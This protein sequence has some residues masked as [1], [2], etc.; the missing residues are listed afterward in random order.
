MQSKIEYKPHPYQE[1][2]TQFI[3][4]HK[5][6]GLLLDMGLGK[7]IITLS[8]IWDLCLDSFEV[9]RVLVVA[10][11]RVCKA[12]WP[13]EI[14]KFS[15]LEGLS[16]SVVV[17]S[18][19]ERRAALAKKAFVYIINRENLV[20]LIEEG[21]FN[22][23]LLVL[24]EL[25]SFKSYNTKRFRAL[26]KVRSS[27]KRVIGL[28]GTPGDLMS[29]WPQIYLLDGGERL[30]HFITA[31][32]NKYFLPDKR[33][34]TTIFS[35]KPKEGAEDII[36]EKISDI[37]ISMKSADYLDMPK[38][39]KNNVEV[40]MDEKE[41]ALYEQLKRDL[42]VPMVDGDIDAQSAVGLS[43]KLMQM[44]SGM[45]YD[46]NGVAK[47]IHD[48][49]LDVVEDLIESAAGRPI[50]IAY[51]FKFDKE[52]LIERFGAVPIESSED[53]DSWNRDEIPVGIIHPASASMGI[54]LQLG[55]CRSLVYL[56]TPW[57]LELKAQCDARLYRQGQKNTITIYHLVSKNT[58][59]ED[60]LAALDRKD[61]TQEAILAAVKAR[62]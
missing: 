36:Y 8:A 7:T 39:V 53:I 58:I 11:L 60:I 48:R 45:V 32:R 47:K 33:N 43:L 54:N 51:W 28:T 3:L 34:Q 10:P 15:N 13:T 9:S 59:D 52:R 41:T 18:A 2:C 16:Y 21:Y 19:K 57:S 55:S 27:V 12:T 50:L 24:D 49:K 25:S 20:W 4:N 35:W 5:S 62:I 26:K 56:T 22:F 17:G 6:C 46:E 30:E 61:S 42:I 1:Y 23:D 40:E 37:C 14:T 44:A 29:L 31:Y 38:L